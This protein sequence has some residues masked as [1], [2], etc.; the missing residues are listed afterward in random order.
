MSAKQHPVELSG[1]DRSAV[2]R[3]ARSYRRSTR[4]RLRA[5]VQVCDDSGGCCRGALCAPQSRDAD[6]TAGAAANA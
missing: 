1:E 5:R 6:G 4:E 2:E 3:V